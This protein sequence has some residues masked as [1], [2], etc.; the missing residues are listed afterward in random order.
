MLSDR[1]A[2]YGLLFQKYLVQRGVNQDIYFGCQK[3]VSASQDCQGEGIGV[4]E[5]T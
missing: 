2:S 1:P 3:T 5:M 4:V